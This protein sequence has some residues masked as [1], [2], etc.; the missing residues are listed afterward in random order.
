MVGIAL[1]VTA[2]MVGSHARCAAASSSRPTGGN[3]VLR[4]AGSPHTKEERDISRR[5]VA[6]RSCR[7][8]SPMRAASD[9]WRARVWSILSP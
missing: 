9:G 4:P 8:P 1:A 6:A 7:R 3:S 2:V 5:S